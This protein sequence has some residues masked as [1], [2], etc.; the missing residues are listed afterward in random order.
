MPIRQRILYYT[1][2]ETQTSDT[3]HRESLKVMQQLNNMSLSVTVNRT[4]Y[5]TLTKNY[6]STKKTIDNSTIPPMQLQETRKY[7]GI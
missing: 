6:V 4:F 3:T 5:S 7:P 1:K 2:R